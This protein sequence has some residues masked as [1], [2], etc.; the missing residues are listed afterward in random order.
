MKISSLDISIP[1]AEAEARAGK[2]LAKIHGLENCVASLRDG[3]FVLRR[4]MGPL[5]VELSW[6]VAPLATPN[7]IVF[8]LA[9]VKPSVLGFGGGAIA[10][11]VMGEIAKKTASFP[12]L[13]VEGRAVRVDA[14][15][16]LKEKLGVT[17]E[18][19]IK[20]LAITREKI[21]IHF[22]STRPGS[23]RLDNEESL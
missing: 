21:H 13:R 11:A 17:L 6:Q 20:R 23:I 14:A 1:A 19:E 2:W 7:E 3:G 16:V 12:G 22:D 8:T 5:A 10:D 4:E 18:G 9:G 15:V